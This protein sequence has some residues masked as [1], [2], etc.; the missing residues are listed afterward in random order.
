MSNFTAE[1]DQELQATALVTFEDCQGLSDKDFLLNLAA[2]KLPGA[3][4]RAQ[5]M[6]R[7]SPELKALRSAD[8]KE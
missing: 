8:K 7:V 2:A 1:S 4:P 5:L 6:K 3:S